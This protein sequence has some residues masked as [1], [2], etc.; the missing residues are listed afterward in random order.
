MAFI[1]ITLMKCTA[2]KS[3]STAPHRIQEVKHNSKATDTRQTHLC[4]C[5]VGAVFTNK[6]QTDDFEANVEDNRHIEPMSLKVA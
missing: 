3:K 2:R 1:R 5:M 4:W 6:I